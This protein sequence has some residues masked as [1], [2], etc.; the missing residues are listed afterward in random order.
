MLGEILGL[1]GAMAFLGFFAVL[2][3][4]SWLRHHLNYQEAKRIFPTLA[5]ELGLHYRKP[6]D[7]KQIGV[8][9]GKYKGYSVKIDADSNFE[10]ITVRLRFETSL[11]LSMEKWNQENVTFELPRLNRFFR[12]REA[13][14]ELLRKL[15][16][17]REAATVSEAGLGAGYREAA[18]GLVLEPSAAEVLDAFVGRWKGKLSRFQV[19]RSE[20]H[21]APVLGSQ[22]ESVQ[23]ISPAHV[24]ALLPEL[25]EVARAIDGLAPQQNA[26]AST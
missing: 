8:I 4:Q 12:S 14:P 11:N 16:E 22:D 2:I 13:S 24:R 5:Q 21:V 17:K 19:V 18:G 26:A 7:D 3:Y 23:S 6:K 25:I 10:K 15:H 20:I 1:L 9:G